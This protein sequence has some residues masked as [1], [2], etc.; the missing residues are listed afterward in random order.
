MIKTAGKLYVETEYRSGGKSVSEDY[1]EKIL[2]VAVMEKER[3]AEAHGKIGLTLS[4]G[5]YEFVRIDAGVTLP[6]DKDKVKE[7]YQEAFALAMEEV[8]TRA[9][10][11]K[12]TLSE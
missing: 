7:A 3:M 11:A 8:S 2:G 12:A 4:L 10:E 9:Q 6:C 1:E 5:N